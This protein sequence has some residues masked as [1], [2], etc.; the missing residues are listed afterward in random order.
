[1]KGVAIVQMLLQFVFKEKSRLPNTWS[2][3]DLATEFCPRN[4]RSRRYVLRDFPGYIDRYILY[5]GK[6]LR[7]VA[8]LSIYIKRFLFCSYC[9]FFLRVYIYKLKY[10]VNRTNHKKKRSRN[11][12]NF[13]MN[14]PKQ[15][16]MKHQA[17]EANEG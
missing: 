6:W 4:P 15:C 14:Q 10:R 16:K 17:S 13:N 7:S 9:S 11:L 5:F 8:C 1:M 12:L 3:K 2:A